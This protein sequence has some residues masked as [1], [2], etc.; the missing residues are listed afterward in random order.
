V[1][2]MLA[3]I[4]IYGLATPHNMRYVRNKFLWQFFDD[5]SSENI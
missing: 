2:I 1:G 3:R 4:Y 5:I